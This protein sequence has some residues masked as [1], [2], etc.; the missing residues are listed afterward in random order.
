MHDILG[1]LG[2]INIRITESHTMICLGGRLAVARSKLFIIILFFFRWS[3][4]E[5]NSLGRYG[6]GQW[7]A[8]TKEKE[9]KS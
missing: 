6:Q 3:T 9:K 1:D 8:K 4:F 7:N 2:H 5:E